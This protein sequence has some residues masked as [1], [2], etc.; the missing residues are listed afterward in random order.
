V[1][2]RARAPLLTDYIHTGAYEVINLQTA[3]R[4]EEVGMF[5]EGHGA[6]LM[7]DGKK[8][9]ITGLTQEEAKLFASRLYEEMV[10]TVNCP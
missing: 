8:V 2:R 1:A 6:V 3:V 5:P 4:V 7:C 10:V 9:T